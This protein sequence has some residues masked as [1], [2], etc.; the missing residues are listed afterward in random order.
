[1]IDIYP[2]LR[3]IK[4]EKIRIGPNSDGGY[5]LGKKYLSDKIYSYGVGNNVRFEE[6]YIRLYPNTEIFLFDGT[7]ARLPKTV[8]SENPNVKFVNK[9]VYTDNDLELNHSES[10]VMM[11]IEKSE[12][13]IIKSLKSETID[14][15]KQMCIEVHIDKRKQVSEIVD[16]LEKINYYFYIVHIHANNHKQKLYHG[17]PSVFELT[18]INKKYFKEDIIKEDNTFPIKNLDHPNVYGKPDF[19]LQWWLK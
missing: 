13:E 18:L 5:V 8:L 3:P 14:K 9:N 4:T 10:I 16:F 19:V 2:Y 6:H 12:F 17:I 15:I 1:M 7:I 11:D